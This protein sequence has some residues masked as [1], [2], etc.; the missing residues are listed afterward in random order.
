[1]LWVVLILRP[2]CTCIYLCFITNLVVGL[3]HC[4]GLPSPI[5]T[6]DI[7][8]PGWC[9]SIQRSCFLAARY[10]CT[11][12]HAGLRH[13]VILSQG[14]RRSRCKVLIMLR[15]TALREIVLP[16]L[17]TPFMLDVC[18]R[19]VHL[20]A[21]APLCSQRSDIARAV[22]NG[23]F[24]G[25]SVLPWFLSHRSLARVCDWWRGADA[26][27]AAEGDYTFL[28]CIFGDVRWTWA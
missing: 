16:V 10:G 23:L 28:S 1:M 8:L 20:N 24:A 26:A 19:S 25:S 18:Y 17:S 21:C 14:F 5:S 9:T 4:L 11:C 3:F 27:T 7:T 6:S 2:H 13:G 22:G 15:Q 12:I